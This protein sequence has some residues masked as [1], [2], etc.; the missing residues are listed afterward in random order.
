MTEG[1]KVME[2][3]GYF[4]DDGKFFTSEEQCYDYEFN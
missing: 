1:I 3:K 2:V 4:A